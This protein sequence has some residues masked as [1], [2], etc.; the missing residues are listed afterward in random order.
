VLGRVRFVSLYLLAGIGGSVLSLVN[1]PLA[2]QAAGA[3]GAIFGLFGALY[4]VIRHLKLQ[5]N[6]IMITIVANLVFTF[7]IPNI[8]W[9]GHVGGLV[10]GAAIAA[11][12]AYAPK[13]PR[14][15]QVQAVGIALIAVVL[16]GVGFVAAHH[17]YNECPVLVTAHHVPVGCAS[18]PST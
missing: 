14:R 16:A 6:G 11:V 9:R 13:G 10:V 8:D 5:S 17:R 7:A 15:A 12:I 2:E 1:G 4:I 3:S 18:G